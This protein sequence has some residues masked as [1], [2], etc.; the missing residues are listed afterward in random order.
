MRLQRNLRKKLTRK[1]SK[2]KIVAIVGPTASGKTDLSI[3]KAKELDGEILSVDSRQVY[4]GMDIGTAKVTKE[5]MQGV[6]HYGLDFVKPN[7]NYDVVKFQKYARRVIA[8]MHKRGK[9]PILVGGTGFWMDAVIYDMEFPE[10]NDPKLRKQLEDKTTEQLFVELQKLDPD[11]ASIIDGKNKR[12]LIRALEIVK[13]TGKPV[14]LAKRQSQYDVQWI[15]IDMPKDR[16]ERRIRK[17]FMQW[18]DQGLVKEIEQLHKNGVPYKRMRE[19][20]LCYRYGADLL[21]KKI[22]LTEFMDLSI[23]SIVQY[24]KRQM[25]WFKRNKNITWH[26]LK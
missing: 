18:M 15:G 17:R 24:A 25:T 5:E 26:Q 1:Q 2:P 23:I 9:L 6:P 11:R 3:Q 19:L 10:G 12:R 16:L 22:N 13:T 7:T 4:K 21:Q 8:D 14:P 20:G